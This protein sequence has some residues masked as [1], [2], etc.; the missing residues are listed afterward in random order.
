MTAHRSRP[1]K[2][3]SALPPDYQSM[4]IVDACSGTSCKFLQTAARPGADKPRTAPTSSPRF[5]G[6]NRGHA[7]NIICTYGGRRRERVCGHMLC[8][9]SPPQAGF[10]PASHPAILAGSWRDS[11]RLRPEVD[12]EP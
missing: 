7:T 8:A 11:A 10:D 9:L 12:L 4:P 6:S 2:S 5:E 3:G 1:G